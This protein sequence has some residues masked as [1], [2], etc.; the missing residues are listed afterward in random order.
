MSA[1]LMGQVWELNLPHNHQSVLLAFSDH[2]NDDGYNA[3]PGT[4]YVA[5]KTGY[6]ERQVQRI[7]D[8]LEGGGLLL[9]V[10]EATGRAPT[11]YRVVVS[12]GVKKQPYQPKRKRGDKLSGRQI[13]GATSGVSRGDTTT[14][15]E[16]SGE[17]VSTPNGVETSPPDPLIAECDE[18]LV[19]HQRVTGLQPPRP[20][21][22]ARREVE[23]MFS[24][25]RGEGY[26]LADLQIA[27]VGAFND[28]FRRDNGHFGC[29]SVLRPK[30]VH[31]L[32]EKG[33]G[34]QRRSHQRGAGQLSHRD[35]CKRC[36]SK[37]TT[38][39]AN[40]Q[41]GL[42]DDCYAEFLD[43]NGAAA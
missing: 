3:Y 4:G 7:I 36:P 18:W 26:S 1:K 35:T 31:D 12:N 21:T 9:E 24:A 34:F 14:S 27:T 22:V 2:A 15:P 40:N 17:P 11:V 5:W 10:E 28:P 13:V 38:R 33:R 29:I 25:R 16:P 8:E 43:K 37:I 41:S 23:T 19:H 42:C 39:E 20:K 6:S 30:K 32:V